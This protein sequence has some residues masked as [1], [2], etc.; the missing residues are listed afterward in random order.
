MGQVP[1]VPEAYDEDEHIR[2]TF[3][4]FGRAAYMA[5]C[6]KPASSRFCFQIDFLTNVKKEF[7]KKQRQGLQPPKI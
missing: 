1:Q 7:L 4:Y 6:L 3:A 5:S 2:G